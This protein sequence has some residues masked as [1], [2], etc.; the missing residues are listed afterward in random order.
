LREM[1]SQVMTCRTGKA[2]RVAGLRGTG[3]CDCADGHPA[4]APGPFLPS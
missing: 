3:E 2:L 4:A 1:L